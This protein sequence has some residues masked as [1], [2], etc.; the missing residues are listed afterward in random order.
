MKISATHESW[1]LAGEFR[2]S[3]GAKTAADVVV[4]QVE[5]DGVAGRGE[6]VPY[7]RY[8]ETIES[9][10]KQI[11]GSSAQRLTRDKLKHRLSPGAARNAMDCALWDLECKAQG[12]DISDVLG[13]TSDS[14]LSA[15]TLSLD[16]PKAM[17]AAAQQQ[18]ET[19]LLKIKL[20]GRGDLERLRAVR[21][22][23]PLSRLVLDANEAWSV[24]DNEALLPELVALNVEVI[25][26]PFPVG[27]DRALAHL[28][29]P[30]TI[31]ADESCHDA[32]SIAGL[33]ERYDMVNV[34]LDKTGGLSE[35]IETRQ[36]AEDRGLKV[37]VGCMVGTSLGMAPAFFLAQNV[38]VVDLDG[39]LWLKQDREPGIYYKGTEM[40]KPDSKLWG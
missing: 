33:E 24:A 39:P 4:V 3:R 25:E 26:Q 35:A 6:C 14:L 5:Q 21:A 27:N 38:D 28:D 30:I 29:R 10:L 16:E 31:C 8:G 12:R 18:S 40:H 1:P 19:P 23:A 37:M 11:H 32:K 22:G 7:A 34:K 15:Y 13:T 20:G 9:V 36:A 17:H 2:I